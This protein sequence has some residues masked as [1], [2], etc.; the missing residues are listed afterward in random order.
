MG[1]DIPFGTR[2][3]TENRILKGEVIRINALED[4]P[5]EA[6]DDRAIS[7]TD[8]VQSILTIPVRGTTDTVVGAIGMH[9][10]SH[11]Y[12]WLDDDISHLKIVGDSIANLLERKYA[13][14]NLLNAYDTTLEGWAKALELRDKE[15]EG[16]TRRVTDLTMKL[17]QQFD[18]PNEKMVDIRRGA[19]LHDI[20]KLSIPDEILQKPGKLTDDEWKTMS[21]HPRIGY[22]LLT[23]IDFLKGSL[24]I[25]LYHHEKWDGSGYLEG[26][27]GEDIPLAA[28]IFAVVDVW[29]AVQSDRP[30]KKAWSREKALELIKKGSG[31]HFDPNVIRVFLELVKQGEI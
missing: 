27:Q 25:V 2:V 30:Y 3:W 16:H 13:E 24:D 7:Q 15:T 31:N 23:P 21:Q 22:K 29:D 6:L 26:M 9:V 28:R 20:G 17:A 5:T 4:Y 18:I 1:K 19:I 12:I 14:E 8:G 10:Y 11:S